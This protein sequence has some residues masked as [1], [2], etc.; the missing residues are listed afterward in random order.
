MYSP[1]RPS[2]T[3]TYALT[4]TTPV[5][6]DV[7]EDIERRKVDIETLNRF[8]STLAMR[9][10]GAIGEIEMTIQDDHWGL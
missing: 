10:T 7:T 4:W 5:L 6:D 8:W 9:E 1:E 2:K 3:H